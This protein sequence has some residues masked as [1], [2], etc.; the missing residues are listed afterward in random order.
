MRTFS[1]AVWLAAAPLAGAADLYVGGNG[2]D[3][4]TV[5]SPSAPF[6][7]L[8]KAAG[9]VNPGDTVWVMNGTFAPVKLTRPGTAQARITWKAYPG[10]TPEIVST[11]WHAIEVTASWQTID[12][13][14]LTGNNDNVYLQDAEADYA[15]T[16]GSPLYNGNGITL[17]NRQATVKTH[18][19]TVQNCVIRKFGGGGIA[20]I[21]TDY[22]VIENNQVYENAWYSRYGNSGIT[23]FTANAEIASGYRNIIR[24]N[25]MWNNR[26]L[27]M[28]KA[29][30]KYSDGNGFI[31]DISNASYSGRTLVANNLSV[32]NGGSGLHAFQAKHADFVNNTA[33]MNGDKVGYADIYAQESDDIKFYNNVVFSRNG[34]KANTNQLNTNVV[35]DYNVYYNGTREAQGTHDIVGDPHFIQRS[36]DMSVADF[37]LLGDSVALDN[38]TVISGTT[39]VSDID[40]VVRPKGP[41]VDRGAFEYNILPRIVSSLT[42]SG[43]KGTALSYTIGA[44]NYPTSFGAAPLPGGLSV[45]TSTGVISGTPTVSGTFN[46]T[47]S[48]TNTVG[49]G[50]AVVK[51]TIAP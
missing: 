35:Y 46:V 37:R 33:Y 40:G 1:F 14:T 7:S 48:A 11:A 6:R 47:V 13:L 19:L 50:S 31:L 41:G 26:G 17:D 12:G 4:L 27:V 29:K 34:G 45:N 16:D 3:N 20:A 30:G 49:T 25:R 24:G 44:Y 39:P 28:W 21:E 51:F 22:V 15:L 36:L 38:A 5:S 42:V 8:G 10:H 32:G 9:L 43:K 23:L 2:N 18:H